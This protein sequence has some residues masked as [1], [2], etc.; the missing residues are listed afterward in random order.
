M[1]SNEIEN[2]YAGAGTTKASHQAEPIAPG[3]SREHRGVLMG[4]VVL[5]SFVAIGILVIFLFGY[6][7]VR[8]PRTAEQYAQELRNG[9]GS[10]E[11]IS[12][13]RTAREIA[14]NLN[15]P[16]V[17]HPR[18]LAALLDIVACPDLDERIAANMTPDRNRR[19]DMRLRWWA[20]YLAGHIA[21]RL[22][23]SR[24]LPILVKA[25][26]EE[27]PAD[28]EGAAGLRFFAATGLGLLKHAGACE[29]LAKR[30]ATDPDPVVRSACAKSLGAIGS[31]LH[32][33]AAD[34]SVLHRIRA[35]LGT[36]YA[37]DP[38][39]DVKWNAAIAL[40]RAHDDAG[41]E[42]LAQLATS[43]EP[44]IRRNA[45]MALSILDGE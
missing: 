21:G 3:G 16:E 19:G 30:L 34:I 38:D 2:E 20:A 13:W 10:G 28:P 33:E 18:V 25:A 4:M 31:H 37:S 40:A 1:K 12:R 9:V 14:E 27:D 39:T 44:S 43:R 11:G 7:S 42:T 6:L 15:R 32:G 29:V 45:E 36:A 8:T 22:D 23:D 5:P 35:N 17:V 24:A 41:R 26:T